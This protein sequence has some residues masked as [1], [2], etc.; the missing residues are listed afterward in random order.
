[1]RR[2]VSCVLFVVLIAALPAQA[3][4]IVDWVAIGDPGNT[5]DDTGYGSVGYAYQV[6]KYEVTNGEY[7]EFLNAVAATDTYSLYNTDMGS[8]SGGITRSGSSGSYMYGTITGREDRPVNYV[9]WYDSLRFVNWLQNGQLTG[10]QDSTTTEDGA[11]TFSGA[12]S[13]GGRNAG[14]TIVLTSEDEWYKAAY[15]D[16]ALHT[17][18]DY[19]YGT[20]TQTT[21]G[22]PAGGTNSANCNSSVGDLTDF[23]AYPQ[24]LSPSGTA[25]QGGNV[26]EWNEAIL[27]SSRGL[28]GGGWYN[29]VGHLAA[30]NR[31]GDLPV[32]SDDDVGFRVAMIP[33]PGTGLLVL[34]GLL[35][36]AISERRHRL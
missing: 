12:T 24:S 33:E 15:Y 20:D 27:T 5:A 10:A 4:V 17:Y 25:D 32:N 19:P 35:G 18:Y 29:T 6:G 23:G 1:M 14:A 36:L 30:S 11:Y 22:T 9:S 16:S 3:T 7:A 21:C 2:Q 8:G 26:W 13:V 34:A 31:T 28:R